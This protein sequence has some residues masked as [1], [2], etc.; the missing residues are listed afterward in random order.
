MQSRS[1]DLKSKAEKKK[2]KERR[3]GEEEH[4]KRAIFFGLPPQCEGSNHRCSSRPSST[5]DPQSRGCEL[6]RRFGCYYY[7]EDIL[8]K[9]LQ[10]CEWGAASCMVVVVVGAAVVAVEEADSDAYLEKEKDVD[11]EADAVVVVVVAS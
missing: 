3:E 4:K 8:K 6:H 10:R 7:W 1:L 9:P 11:V 5:V 2:K